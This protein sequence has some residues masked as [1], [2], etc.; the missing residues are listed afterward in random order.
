[1]RRRIVDLFLRRR[2]CDSTVVV[3]NSGFTERAG[4]KES[5]RR[6]VAPR[7]NGTVDA[8][9]TGCWMPKSER[10]RE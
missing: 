3:V 4:V 6:E 5:D 2:E 1:M 8:A 10:A 7:G 9:R